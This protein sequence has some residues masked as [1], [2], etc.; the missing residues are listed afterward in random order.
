[1]AFFST[2]GLSTGIMAHDLCR[3]IPVLFY[4][5]RQRVVSSVS[6]TPVRHFALGRF[7][8]GQ[9]ARGSFRPNLVGRFAY[10]F[11]QALWIEV[12]YVLV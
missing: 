4:S 10:I 8:L 3:A 7:A 9:F 11:I 1:M 5:I 2:D 6:H 12:W